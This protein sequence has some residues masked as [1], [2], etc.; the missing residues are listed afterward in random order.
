MLQYSFCFMFWFFDCKACGESELPCVCVL[1]H[2]QLSSQNRDQTC[3]PCF[4]RRSLTLDHQGHCVIPLG[5][6]Y[7]SG[8]ALFSD[9]TV[10][11]FLSIVCVGAQSYLTICDPMDCS[12]PGS[13]V[14]SILQV[15]ILE[16][17]AI[18]FSRGFSQPRDRT[19]SLA[20]P[21]LQVDSLPFE[22][23]EKPRFPRQ[24]YWNRLPFPPIGNLP[25]PGIK[26]TSPSNPLL[27]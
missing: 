11:L 14:H 6:P 21:A 22:P 23:P 4:G 24:E 19:L 12:P 7:G 8:N 5:I 20:S 9:R 2:V 15:R 10:P 1:S 18:L 16:S 25:D 26:A 13:S 3:T 17:V 27:Q